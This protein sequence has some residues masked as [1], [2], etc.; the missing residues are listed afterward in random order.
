MHTFHPSFLIIT[1]A[2]YVLSLLVS[3]FYSEM[4]EQLGYYR[5]C[6]HNSK[7]L[8]EGYKGTL[9]HVSWSYYL[10]YEVKII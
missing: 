6:A 10:T 9:W 3:T 4:K 2:F 5:L 8:L 1:R 7:A